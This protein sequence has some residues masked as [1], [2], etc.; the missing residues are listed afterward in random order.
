MLVRRLARPL[1]AS[2]FVAEGIGAFRR[3]AERAKSVDLTWR[4]IAAKTEAPDPPEQE[5][6]RTAV[7]L[8]GA[9]MAVAGIML[10]LGKAPRL[11]SCTLVILTVPIAAVDFPKPPSEGTG[12]RP[13]AAERAERRDRFVRDLSLIGGALFASLDREGK[14]SLGWRMSHAKLDQTAELKAR[15]A[16]SAADKKVRAVRRQ[17]KHATS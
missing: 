11:A 17:V 12:S 13:S 10:A 4:R 7:K 9:A 2:W 16:V 5:S 8:H 6:L 15:Q 3:P 1:L 14:P